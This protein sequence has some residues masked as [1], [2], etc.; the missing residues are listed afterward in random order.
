MALVALEQLGASPA[1][2]QSV[3][4]AHT[5]GDAEWRDDVEVLDERRREITRDGIAATV[6]SRVCTLVDAPGTALFHAMIRLAYAL[7]VG[8]EG[9][10]AAAL[11]DWERRHDVLPRPDARARFA[12]A[13]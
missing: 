3:F 8:H 9:Q 10:V 4:D 11:L 2:L 7:D 1:V 6:Q 12:P 5:R 13:P